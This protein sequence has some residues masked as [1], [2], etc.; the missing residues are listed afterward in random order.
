MRESRYVRLPRNS[1][2]PSASSA[3]EF[4]SRRLG[5]GPRW[6]GRAARPGR[7]WLACLLDHWEPPLELH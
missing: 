1:F 2:R 5:G 3:L 6:N 7:K 4:H